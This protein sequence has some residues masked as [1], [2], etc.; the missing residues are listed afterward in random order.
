[1][2]NKP[3]TGLRTATTDYVTIVQQVC[4]KVKGFTKLYQDLERSINVSDK[5]KSTLTNYG[6][7][8]AH[9]ALN[10]VFALGVLTKIWNYLVI[11]SFVKF[12]CFGL[13]FTCFQNTTFITKFSALFF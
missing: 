7:H 6:R 9:L 12:N 3:T 2:Q 5:S 13:I 10:A 8:L 4:D 1:M 11:I